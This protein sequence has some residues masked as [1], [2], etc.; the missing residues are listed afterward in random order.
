M[1][2]TWD[3]PTLIDMPA[4][5][6]PKR[7]VVEVTARVTKRITVDRDEVLRRMRRMADHPE[8]LRYPGFAAMD[9]V[10]DLV[11][12]GHPG[13]DAEW[14]TLDFGENWAALAEELLHPTWVPKEES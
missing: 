9:A 12:E 3:Q 6:E 11:R 4:T 1:N 5:H 14:R 10:D 7:I 8:V 13:P 2:D